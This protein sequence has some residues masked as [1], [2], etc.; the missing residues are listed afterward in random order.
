MVPATSASS[1]MERGLSLSL[2]SASAGI[3]AIIMRVWKRCASERLLPLNELTEHSPCSGLCGEGL[4]IRGAGRRQ[5][6]QDYIGRGSADQLAADPCRG[7]A[8]ERD[9]PKLPKIVKQM[10]DL[11]VLGLPD[12]LVEAA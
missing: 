8:V 6:D 9:R 2:S 7:G 3:T 5:I 10:F 4:R 11:V 1:T 12:R